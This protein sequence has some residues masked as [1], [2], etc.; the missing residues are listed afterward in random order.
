MAASSLKT[1]LLLL[2]FALPALAQNGGV[3]QLLDPAQHLAQARTAFGNGDA[4]G[5]TRHLQVALE[6]AALG[7]PQWQQAYELAMQRRSDVFAQALVGAN[8]PVPL[9]LLPE[10]DVLYAPSELFAIPPWGPLAAYLG[11]NE[12]ESFL[13]RI[14]N[15]QWQDAAHVIEEQLDRTR[16]HIPA[17]MLVANLYERKEQLA[18]AY[19]RYQ[20]VIEKAQFTDES[21]YFAAMFGQF[22]TQYRRQDFKAAEQTLDRYLRAAQV[23]LSDAMDRWKTSPNGRGE[24]YTTVLE[25]RRHLVEGLNAKGIIL[26]L[27]KADPMSSY[28]FEQAYLLAPGS[29][30]IAL[31]RNIM[32][33]RARLAATVRRGLDTLASALSGLEQALMAQLDRQIDSGSLDL[34]VPLTFRELLRHQVAR[35]R[36]RQGLFEISENQDRVGESFLTQAASL[37]DTSAIAHYF[38]GRQLQKKD[39]LDEALKHFQRAMSVGSPALKIHGEARKR[40]DEIFELQGLRQA[41]TRTRDDQL[42]KHFEDKLDPAQLQ[43]M[44]RDIAECVE[45]LQQGEFEKARA[46]LARLSEYHKDNLEIFRFLGYAN[47]EL[48]NFKE[49]LI[50][51]DKALAIDKADP[52]SLS[53]KAICLY[54]HLTDL[55]NALEMAQKAVAIKNDD[56]MLLS[57]MGWLLVMAHDVR[58]GAEAIKQ[59]IA[60]APKDP[61]HHMRLA[62][63]YYNTSQWSFAQ[64]KFKDVLG[65]DPKHRK[66]AVFL[67]ITLA[68]M[69]R[70]NESIDQLSSSLEIVKSDPGL[71]DLVI[72]NLAL[73]KGGGAPVDAPGPKG[74]NDPQLP[75][76][77]NEIARATEANQRLSLARD[78]V[79]RGELAQAKVVLET[80][81]KDFPAAAEV[82]YAHAFLLIQAGTPEALAAARTA[83]GGMIDLNTQDARAYYG[84]A[85]VLFRE[86]KVQEMADTLARIAGMPDGLA[87]SEFLDALARRWAQVLDLDKSDQKA[88]AELGLVYLYQGKL[89]EAREVLSK[90]TTPAGK[91]TFA[92]VLLRQFHREK[93][94]LD[95]QE[96][97]AAAQFAGYAHLPQLD[98]FW[99]AVTQPKIAAI[100][101]VVVKDLRDIPAKELEGWERMGSLVKDSAHSISDAVSKIDVNKLGIPQNRRWAQIE[102][103]RRRRQEA[104]DAARTHEQEMQEQD[105]RD[106]AARAEQQR[107]RKNLSSPGKRAA[108]PRAGLPEPI[109]GIVIDDDAAPKNQLRTLSTRQLEAGLAHV[110]TG[111]LADAAKEFRGAI[112]LDPTNR[113]AYLAL[114]MALAVGRDTARTKPVLK[115]VEQKFGQGVTDLAVL[116]HTAWLDGDV[117]GAAR[118]WAAI[119][120]ARER[121]AAARKGRRAKTPAPRYIQISRQAWATTLI[122]APGDSDA[123]LALAQLD[124]FAG[125]AAAALKRLEPLTGT[126]EGAQAYAEA[127]LFAAA[128]GG[129]EK[130]LASAIRALAEIEG[131]ESFSL[132]K[133]LKSLLARSSEPRSSH[134]PG[135]HRGAPAVPR[136]ERRS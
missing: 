39:Q 13:F 24:L 106:K 81:H 119:K 89:K 103:S 97:Q 53:Q 85:H 108:A 65:L 80:A 116:G 21:A 88:M 18:L 117:Q 2:F 133:R 34:G 28:Q 72:K 4:L 110:K 70:T 112:S 93:R 114:A 105:K 54:E 30:P 82:T 12:R 40:V 26:A 49:A 67:G 104:I 131:A 136:A 79:V 15:N 111:R 62:M 77:K 66:A 50:A 94:Q 87:F 35:V 91:L 92:E 17:L 122:D 41:A 55:P 102:Q 129:G 118:A 20:E 42:R 43:I 16:N 57:N 115:T 134:Q 36:V 47:Q 51:Y 1:L 37:A 121:E 109:G 52:W 63:A 5:G 8:F 123:N 124:L 6:C 44:R 98:L 14:N 71:N 56:P 100:E 19:T 32:Q 126:F 45:W 29:I 31:N 84:L 48:A 64:S 127:C 130:H 132:Q 96:A 11:P 69:G 101:Q 3:A 90:A 33:Q 74:K 59:A 7:T 46:H 58:Q 125:E 78:L 86:G 10:D 61:R 83:I 113:D 25:G 38:L 68:R 22:R 135:S 60:L 23:H 27:R 107:I 73:L 95:F 75:L 99:R 9:A 128:T 120:P 76:T